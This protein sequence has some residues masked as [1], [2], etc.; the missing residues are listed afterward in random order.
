MNHDEEIN[1]MTAAHEFLEY[2]GLKN[3]I[4][5]EFDVDVHIEMFEKSVIRQSLL[6]INLQ[7]P[8]CKIWL[9][10]IEHKYPGVFQ[11]RYNKYTFVDE[12]YLL[13]EGTNKDNVPFKIS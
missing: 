12:S 10:D 8:A 4:I 3:D 1:S 7:T 9:H 13:I 11:P 6:R 2:Y 5:I